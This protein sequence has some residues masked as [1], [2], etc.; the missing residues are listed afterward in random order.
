M[1][2]ESTV[3]GE[4]IVG[5]EE[6]SEEGGAVVGGV[7]VDWNNERKEGETGARRS[8]RAATHRGQAN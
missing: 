7:L 5:V 2:G 8:D 4:S 6:G 1:G 3:G